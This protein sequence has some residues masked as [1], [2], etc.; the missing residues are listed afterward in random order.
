MSGARKTFSG[1]E[2][3]P[4]GW[5]RVWPIDEVRGG[6]RKPSQAGQGSNDRGM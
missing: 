5:L 2:L 3:S 1:H 6:R 4:E